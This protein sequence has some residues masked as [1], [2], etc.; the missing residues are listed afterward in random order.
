MDQRYLYTTRV[1]VFKE[2]SIC[3]VNW[4]LFGEIA[5]Y[6]LYREDLTQAKED[7]SPTIR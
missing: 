2:H 7:T 5:I 1:T 3:E 6:L 4:Q